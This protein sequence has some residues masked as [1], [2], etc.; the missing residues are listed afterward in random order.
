MPS[1]PVNEYRLGVPEVAAILGVDEK[2]VR[3]WADA[4]QLPCWRTPGGHRRFRR[5]DV[6]ALLSPESEVTK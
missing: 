2:S 1:T 4:G 3:S 6:E 5:S